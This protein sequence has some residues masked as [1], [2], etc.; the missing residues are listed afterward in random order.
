MIRK[1]IE[2]DFERLSEIYNL[3]KLDE[4]RYEPEEFELLSL[5]RDER[6]RNKIFESDI[7]LYCDGE[8]KGF[9]AIYKSEIRALFVCPNYRGC[10]IGQAL[11]R[12]AL[13]SI[14]SDM[15]LFVAH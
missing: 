5:D 6:R 14:S 2:S 3:S 9:I 15:C 4:L 12:F 1:Y 11:L 7:Y 8:T 10:G 13:T